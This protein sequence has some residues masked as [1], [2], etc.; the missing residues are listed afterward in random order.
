M[1]VILQALIMQ[2]IDTI[3]INLLVTCI[4]SIKPSYY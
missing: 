2:V 3:I 1:S 4:F